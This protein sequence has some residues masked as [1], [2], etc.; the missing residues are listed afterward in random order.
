[1]LGDIG[2]DRSGE[3]LAPIVAGD[4]L[5]VDGRYECS[6]DQGRGRLCDRGRGGTPRDGVGVPEQDL[7]VP[8]ELCGKRARVDNLAGA[9]GVIAWQPEAIKRNMKPGVLASV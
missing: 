4:W 7:E 3:V 6:P 9:R 5:L 1:M 2:L 8:L